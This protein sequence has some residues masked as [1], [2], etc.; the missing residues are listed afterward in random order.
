MLGPHIGRRVLVGG[1]DWLVH[2]AVQTLRWIHHV[3]HYVEV[4]LVQLLNNL[5]RIWECAFVKGE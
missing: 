4:L 3:Q 1:I 5:G 2:A